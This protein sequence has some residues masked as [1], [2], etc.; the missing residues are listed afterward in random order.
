MVTE[1]TVSTVKLSEPRSIKQGSCGA[2]PGT[3]WK[4]ESVTYHGVFADASIRSLLHVSK[5][6]SYVTQHVAYSNVQLACCGCGS[7]RGSKAP[8]LYSCVY[9][10]NPWKL[11]NRTRNMIRT[12]FINF[13]TCQLD[14]KIFPNLEYVLYALA[15]GMSMPARVP[16][17]VPL[18]TAIGLDG[19]LSNPQCEAIIRSDVKAWLPG[20]NYHAICAED[21]K[22]V[23][24][25]NYLDKRGS[26]KDVGLMVRQLCALL[27]GTNGSAGLNIRQT[28][29]CHK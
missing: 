2:S 16:G 11:G 4:P 19:M 21:V 14:L 12:V 6:I 22:Q 23:F 17:G 8:N 10:P 5:E 27:C 7:R 13:L 15:D 26:T 28:M 29:E 20:G 9:T 3:Q 25:M 1:A 24:Q 18:R